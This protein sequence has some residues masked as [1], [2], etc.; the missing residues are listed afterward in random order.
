MILS[1]ESKEA[2]YTCGIPGYMHGPITR[3]YEDHLPPGSFLTAVIDNDLKEACGR[4]DDTNRHRLF[5]YMMWFY[6]H[7]PAGTWGRQ[8]ATHDWLMKGADD[9]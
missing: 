3:F 5:D 1:N 9:A 6:N 4:A 8:G 7:A 2:L